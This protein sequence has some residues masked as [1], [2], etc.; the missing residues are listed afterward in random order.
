MS[1]YKEKFMKLTGRQ[2]EVVWFINRFKKKFG[3]GP[4]VREIM[5]AMKITSPNGVQCH[6]KA[7]EK[8][9]MITK[10]K[11]TSRSI[12]ITDEAAVERQ[13]GKDAQPYAWET[14]E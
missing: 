4:S 6:L 9:G 11:K 12:V 10:K 1:E 2:L 8:K 7:L 14:T 5:E 3:Y 13:R